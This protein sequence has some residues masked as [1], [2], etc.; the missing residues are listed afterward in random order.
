MV[1]S[2]TVSF[3]FLLS[4]AH[5]FFFEHLHLTGPNSRLI[6]TFLQLLPLIWAPMSMAVLLSGSSAGSRKLPRSRPE[7]LRLALIPRISAS[8]SIS[9]VNL[10]PRVF[11]FFFLQ[12]STSTSTSV[13]ESS[14]LYVNQ[15]TD[16][17]QCLNDG[18]TAV[19][20][21]HRFRSIRK[22]AATMRLG[23][24]IASCPRMPST[25]SHFLGSFPF[26]SP[27]RNPS[28]DL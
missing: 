19:A 4:L 15:V 8:A 1:R 10:K 28:A 23:I 11:N 12:H 27:R 7:Q 25:T 20:L 14:R 9:K 13:D 26:C 21:Q 6:L 18:T 2:L 24:A 5:F 3:A 17:A 22:E 16:I